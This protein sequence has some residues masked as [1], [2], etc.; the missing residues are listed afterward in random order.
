MLSDSHRKFAD[1][2]F[3]TLNAKQSAIYAGYAESGAAVEGHRLLAREDVQQYLDQLRTEF[4]DK[5][6]ISREKVLREV[7]RIAFADIRNYYEGDTKLKAIEDLD[8]DAAA[9]LA[10][11]KTYEEYSQGEAIGINKEIKLYNKLDGLEKLARHLGLYEKD[12][13]QTRSQN[14]INFQ[15]II[16]ASGVPIATDEKDVSGG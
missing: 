5:T 2:Y 1:R 10:S 8:D 4:Y 9:A 7:A 12:N 15:P 16:N 3:E 6:S 14:T 13:D 11:V